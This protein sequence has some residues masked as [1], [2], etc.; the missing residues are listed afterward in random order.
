MLKNSSFVVSLDGLISPGLLIA[1]K[2][3]PTASEESLEDLRKMSSYYGGHVIIRNQS[4]D[5]RID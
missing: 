5:W 4:V 3:R 2:T 1:T